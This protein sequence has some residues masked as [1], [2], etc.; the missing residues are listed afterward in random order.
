MSQQLIANESIGGLVQLLKETQLKYKRLY[1]TDCIKELA[2]RPATIS[3]KIQLPSFFRTLFDD[4]SNVLVYSVAGR[5]YSF[6]HSFLYVL[7]PGFVDKSWYERKGLVDTFID[8]LNHDV[9]HYFK[10]DPILSKT[11]MNS[12][13]VR[14]HDN[15]P[16]DELK[17]YLASRFNINLI[18]VDTTM[19]N[20]TFK[21]Y[22]F[23]PDLPT[24]ILYRDDTP[25]YHVLSINDR[26]LFSQID[27]H[28]KLVLENLLQLAPNINTILKQF[29]K[30]GKPDEPDR[31]DVYAQVNGLTEEEKFEL[32]VKPG[33]EKLKLGELQ[34][35]ALRYGLSTE[36]QGKIKA[37]AM[38]KKEI[39][40]AI[41]DFHCSSGL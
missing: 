37:K 26:V 38:T 4:Q 18:F 33:L 9:D 12:S 34:V 41:I 23:N 6:W 24:L 39:I 8:E 11:T 2:P 7:Y 20:F 40:A 16:S 25:I 36:K 1:F 15:M 27:E 21:G 31:L 19:L 30:I 10:T 28:D 29:T 5:K 35:L 14:F 3:I 22:K 13:F 17:Y 32:E